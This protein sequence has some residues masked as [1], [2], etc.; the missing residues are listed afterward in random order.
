MKEEELYTIQ[1]LLNQLILHM[2]TFQHI[3]TGNQHM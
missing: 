3:K 2:D 1:G